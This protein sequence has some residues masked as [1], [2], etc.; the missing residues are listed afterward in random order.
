VRGNS[1]ARFLG[2]CRRVNRLHLPRSARISKQTK[3]M[4][5]NTTQFTPWRPMLRITPLV[6]LLASLVA[7]SGQ[8]LYQRL[9]SFDGPSGSQPASGMVEGSDGLLYGATFSGGSNN[10]RGTVFQM[11]KDGTGFLVLRHFANDDQGNRPVGRV[12]GGTDGALYGTTS[13]GGTNNA[14]TVFKLNKDGSGYSVLRSFGGT[15]EDGKN[16]QTGVIEGSDGLLYGTTYGAGASVPGNVFRISKDGSAFSVLHR[17]EGTADGQ[18]PWGELLEASDGFLY[19]TTYSGTTGSSLFGTVFRISKDGS[20]YQILHLFSYLVPANG[21]YPYGGL[22]EATDGQLYGTTSAGGSAGN[23]GT[24]FK[25]EKSGSGYQVIFSF[26]GDG[27]A[28]RGSLLE[29]PSGA[30]YGVTYDGGIGTNGTVFTL[31]TNGSNYTV[32]HRFAD[33]GDGKKPYGNLLSATD[34]AIYG[35]TFSGGET[36]LGTVFRLFSFPPRLKLS[37]VSNTETGAVVE[38]SGGAAG[39]TYNVEATTNLGVAHAWSVLGSNSAAIDGRFRFLDG[40][41][42][43]HQSRFYRGAIP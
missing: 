17:F 14:G 35:T 38:V 40:S 32:L 31:N 39:A 16:P 42:T 29:G 9:R 28:P 36:N 27:A 26:T 5:R 41:A 1:H 10:N 24:V 2:G 6:L 30:L 22:M 33:G 15:Y 7:V 34:G 21:L 12:I 4:K 25:I 18:F 13:S 8:T 20:A 19:G 3:I 37:C 43:N 11:R 23:Y